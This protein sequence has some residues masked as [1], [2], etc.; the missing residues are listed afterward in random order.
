MMKH[1]RVKAA[2][3]ILLLLLASCSSDE[4]SQLFEKVAALNISRG[5]YTLGKAITDSQRGIARKHPVEAANPWTFKFKDGDLYVVADK[6]T[7]RVVVLYEQ[8]EGVGLN[9]VQELVGALS[10]EYGDPTVMAH[11]KIVYWA[12]GPEG[13]LTREEYEEAKKAGAKLPI[14]ATVKL[15]SSMRILGRGPAERGSVYYIV[16]SEP[17]LK[18]IDS[19]WKGASR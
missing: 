9:K 19:K 4:L 1:G 11:D 3:L 2:V 18:L 13:K 10:L 15:K 14:L 7:G 17:V 6:S 12:F 16:S 8:Y 5:G